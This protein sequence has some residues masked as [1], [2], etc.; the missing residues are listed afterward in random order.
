MRPLHLLSDAWRL[1][2]DSY[3]LYIRSLELEIAVLVRGMEDGR[4]CSEEPVLAAHAR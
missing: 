3:I 1:Y 2:R 4:G